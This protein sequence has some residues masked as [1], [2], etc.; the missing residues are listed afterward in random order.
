MISDAVF[1]AYR[2]NGDTWMNLSFDR[3][4]EEVV[5]SIISR[6]KA[7]Q[8]KKTLLSR[9]LALRLD[10][11]DFFDKELIKTTMTHKKKKRKLEFIK[12]VMD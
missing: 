10:R 7:S 5:R 6:L 1:L 12:V 2:N 8:G 3:I 4:G 9:I 11:R